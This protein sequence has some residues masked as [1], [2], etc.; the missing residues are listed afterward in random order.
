MS[1]IGVDPAY[2]HVTGTCDVTY[3]LC[4][5]D[6]DLIDSRILSNTLSYYRCSSRCGCFNKFII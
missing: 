2:A 3:N 5:I 4:D 1:S 6:I